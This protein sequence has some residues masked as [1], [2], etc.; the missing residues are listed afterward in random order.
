MNAPLLSQIDREL[1]IDLSR[2]PSSPA[3]F[4][5]LKE[6][7]FDYVSMDYITTLTVQPGELVQK[8]I[9]LEQDYFF[10]ATGV[11]VQHDQPLSPPLVQVT[12]GKRQ[13]D[14]LPPG[15][16]DSSVSF[17]PGAAAVL[18]EPG[19][20]FYP[21]GEMGIL[22]YSVTNTAATAAEITVIVS[23]WKVPMGVF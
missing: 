12:D 5:R 11:A 2:F 20:I 7:Q 17:G 23:G 16:V 21:F 10:F 6:I 4:K 15:G 14:L 18:A 8:R 22:L 9:I 13:K 3:G 19:S 1:L